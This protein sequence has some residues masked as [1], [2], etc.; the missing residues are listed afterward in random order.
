MAK[1]KGLRITQRVPRFL[2]GELIGRSVVVAKSS[3]K[4][5][6]GLKGLV[7]DETRNTF[8]IETSKGRKLVPKTGNFFK[9]EGEKEVIEG[10][11]LECRPED[12]TKRLAPFAR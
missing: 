9:F 11:L 8:L 12:R 5:M 6:Q 1:S 10:L 7:L 3:Q 2:L 4:E